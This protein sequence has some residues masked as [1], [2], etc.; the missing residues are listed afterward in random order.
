MIKYLCAHGAGVNAEAMDSMTALHF[1]G[2]GHL[3]H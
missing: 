2:E 3:P 1:A